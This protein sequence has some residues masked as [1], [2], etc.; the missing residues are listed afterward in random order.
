MIDTFG[1]GELQEVSRLAIAGHE[2]AQKIMSREPKLHPTD[3]FYWE[4]FLRLRYDQ[5][6]GMG[7]VGSIPWSSIERY[8]ER[9]DIDGIDYEYF[10][11]AIRHVEADFARWVEHQS[12]RTSH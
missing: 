7:G 2:T 3:Q 8:A 11:S 1:P 4:S 10:E 5:P 12:K 9:Y 6:I